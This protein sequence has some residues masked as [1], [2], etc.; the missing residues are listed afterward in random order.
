MPTADALTIETFSDLVHATAGPRC[1][2]AGVGR[3]CEG[4]HTLQRQAMPGRQAIGCL[5]SRLPPLE[6]ARP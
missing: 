6:G 3:R 4:L 2:D 1:N 5:H